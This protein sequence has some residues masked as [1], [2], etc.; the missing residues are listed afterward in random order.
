MQPEKTRNIIEALIRARVASKKQ[1]NGEAALYHID[2]AIDL[3]RDEQAIK[4]PPHEQGLIRRRR[5]TFR[6]LCL[7]S[8][9]GC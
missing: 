5:V 8:V 6:Y 7:M 2:T 1:I 4:K 3:L 9:G